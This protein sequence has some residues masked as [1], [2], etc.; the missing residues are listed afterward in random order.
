MKD[1]LRLNGEKNSRTYIT[2]PDLAVGGVAF[3]DGAEDSEA[4]L[5]ARQWINAVQTGTAPTV[6]P[7]QAIVVTQILEAIYESA[8][9]GKP[10]YFN[11]KK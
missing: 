9:S 8:K 2:R 4:D 1:G 7:E 3:Y 10:V 6:L 5:E 11:N